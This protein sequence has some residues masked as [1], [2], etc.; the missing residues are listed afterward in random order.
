MKTEVHILDTTT[1]LA[2]HKSEEPVLADGEFRVFLECPNQHL[3]VP[4]A[5]GSMWKSRTSK[6]TRECSLHTRDLILYNSSLLTKCLRRAI[7]TD[8]LDG[9][10]DTPHIT[11]ESIGNNRKVRW[12]KTVVIDQENIGEILCSVATNELRDD[13][14]VQ[15][16]PGVRY[17]IPVANRGSII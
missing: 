10:T 16:R 17:A 14:G 3:F 5:N 8:V 13:L 2:S 12:E 1:Q 9:V 7:G 15:M 11:H 4:Y 6:F